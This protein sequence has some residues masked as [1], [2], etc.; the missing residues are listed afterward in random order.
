MISN[1]ITGK[2]WKFSDNISTD[3]IMPGFAAL[4][5]P[6]LSPEEAAQYCMYSNRPD[7]AAMVQ[8]GDVI[9]AGKNFGCGSSRPASRILKTLG[10]DLVVAESIA[11]IFFRNSINLG[12]PVLTCLNILDAFDEG[13][14]IEANISTGEIKNL[15][16]G[17]T[18]LGEAL[19]EDSP[20]M[21]ILR[22]GGIIPMLENE[23]CI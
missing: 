3:L 17:K 1:I 18:I 20:P 7:W 6:D 11:R 2:V 14:I 9:I 13:D 15:T 8:K 10:I 4:S 23:K 21:E 5:R 19:P 16:S 22:A 12:L